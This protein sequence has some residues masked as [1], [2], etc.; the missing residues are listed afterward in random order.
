MEGRVAVV[1][2]DILIE[3]VR[4][5]VVFEWL[6]EPANHRLI[7]EGAFAGCT[8][9]SE[10]TYSLQV[11]TGP[12]TRTMLWS[13]DHADDSHGGRR[14]Y[15]KTDGKRFRGTMSFSLRTMKPSTNTLATLHF[16]F[17]PGGVL[18]GLV[19]ASGLEASLQ[20]GMATCLANLVKHLPHA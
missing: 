15:V 2:T 8:E 3:G 18:G 1:T 12:R 14:V 13:F 4:R 5:D 17:D 20:K 19:M 6:R 9:Q 10:G 11:V 16:D 7:V